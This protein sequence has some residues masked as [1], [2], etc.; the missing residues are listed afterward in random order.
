MSWS[1]WTTW[2]RN[3]SN[4]PHR[5]LL[6]TDMY[7]DIFNCTIKPLLF[8]K[9]L[10]LIITRW[11][12]ITSAA[13]LRNCDLQLD[14]CLPVGI[15]IKKY[16]TCKQYWWIKTGMRPNG[17]LSLV[18]VSVLTNAPAACYIGCVW[19]AWR[20][21]AS[22][23]REISDICPLKC[24]FRLG[25]GSPYMGDSDVISLYIY[26]RWFSPPSYRQKLKILRNVSYSAVT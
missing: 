19:R 4:S 26:A 17:W 22:V 9:M 25:Y 11:Y 20:L 1:S 6:L 3:G 16:C 13:R 10:F 23:V 21:D 5:P 7:Q 24:P 8:L 18:A 14:L 2:H 15:C 12:S